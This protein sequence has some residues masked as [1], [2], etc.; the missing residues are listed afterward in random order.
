MDATTV[1]VELAR[2]CSKWSRRSP[3][4]IQ[5][6]CGCKTIPGVGVLTATGP[7]RCGQSYSRLS[8]GARIRE[9]AGADASRIFNG[10]P[11]LL[12]SDQQTGRCPP[13]LSVR[14]RRA[15]LARRVADRAARTPSTDAAPTGSATATHRGRNKAT[16]AL[17]NKLARIVWAVWRHDDV[18]HAQPPLRTAV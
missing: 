18:F 7:G 13:V 11:T 1:A 15:G 6:L 3:P 8:T 4:T 10:W 9:L 2:T 12:R 17:A 5:W 16:I 14:P